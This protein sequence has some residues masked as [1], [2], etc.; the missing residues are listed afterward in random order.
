MEIFNELLEQIYSS[1]YKKVTFSI[2]NFIENDGFIDELFCADKTRYGI[3]DFEYIKFSIDDKQKNGIKYSKKEY[4]RYFKAFKEYVEKDLQET[5]IPRLRIYL[6]KES[7]SLIAVRL[8]SFKLDLTSDLTTQQS[9]Q[10]G[11]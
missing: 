11:D 1:P 9:S 3:D 7:G 5:A 6:I 2:F 4:T 8:S 10:N